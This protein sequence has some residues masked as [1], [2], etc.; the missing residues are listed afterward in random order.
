MLHKNP[1]MCRKPRAA[2]RLERQCSHP[3]QKGRNS[4]DSYFWPLTTAQS[5]GCSAHSRGAWTLQ[6]WYEGAGSPWGYPT[7]ALPS[8]A[9]PT[10]N[11]RMQQRGV[12]LASSGVP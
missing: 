12:V 5:R 7:L 3:A 1:L 4:N 9:P 2:F 10:P 8:P 11:S 6:T